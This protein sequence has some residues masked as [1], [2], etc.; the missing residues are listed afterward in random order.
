MATLTAET[1]FSLLSFHIFSP[2][3]PY[4]GLPTFSH[5]SKD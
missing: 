4:P 5:P 2:V 1:I 3:L